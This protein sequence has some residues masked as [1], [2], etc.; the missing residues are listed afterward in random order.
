MNHTDIREM[1]EFLAKIRGPDP[2]TAGRILE[3]ILR[4]L[5]PPDAGPPQKTPAPPIIESKGKY[6]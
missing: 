1:L 2:E 5:K 4:S 3:R 6:Q